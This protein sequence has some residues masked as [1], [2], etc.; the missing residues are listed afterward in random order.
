MPFSS[1]PF[2]IL[3]SSRA[4]AAACALVL[5]APF[6]AAQSTALPKSRLLLDIDQTVISHEGSKPNDFLTIG[7]WTYFAATGWEQIGREL[8]RTHSITGKTELVADINSGKASSFPGNFCNVGP[9]L[10]FAADGGRYGRE[11]WRSD[12][13]AKGTYLVKDVY[14]SYPSSVPMSL[15]AFGNRLVF[16]AFDG[17]TGWELWISDGT[18]AGTVLLKDIVR[19]RGSSLP[20]R[21]VVAGNTLFFTAT[22]PAFGT[23]LWKTDGTAKGTSLAR[24]VFAGPQSAI[25]TDSNLEPLGNKVLFIAKSSLLDFEP[26]VSDGTAKGTIRLKPVSRPLASMLIPSPFLSV[27]K[28]AYFVANSP[29]G[30]LWK[31]DGTV[32]GTV[33]VTVFSRN[34]ISSTQFARSGSR[35][36]LRIQLFAGQAN[37]VV[38]DGTAVGTQALASFTSTKPQPFVGTD[39]GVYLQSDGRLWYSSGTKAGTKRVVLPDPFRFGADMHDNRSGGVLFAG[40]SF[41]GFGSELWKVDKSQRVRL[42]ADINKLPGNAG[43]R[44]QRYFA[45]AGLAWFIAW[46]NKRQIPEIWRTDGTTRGTFSLDIVPSTREFDPAVLGRYVY[47]TGAKADKVEALWRSDGT[48]A[49]T[50]ALATFKNAAPNVAVAEGKIFFVGDGPALWVSDGT[51][52]GTKK[53][54]DIAPSPFRGGYY[55]PFTVMKGHV[56][57]EN[58]SGGAWE[59]WKSDGTKAGTKF[60]AATHADNVVV[61]GD[62]LYF[63]SR[64][65]EYKLWRS[66]GTTKGTKAIQT[67]NPRFERQ[68]EHLTAVGTKVFFVR[69]DSTGRYAAFVTGGGSDSVTRLVYLE[70]WRS[71]SG[72]GPDSPFGVVGPRV[73]VSAADRGLVWVTDG[74]RAGTRL[75]R[76]FA[77]VGFRVNRF[78]TLGELVT[79]AAFDAKSNKVMRWISDGTRQGTRQVSSFLPAGV[80]NESFGFPLSSV[81]TGGN[82]YFAAF[83]PDIRWEP[84]VLGPLAQSEVVVPGCAAGKVPS[85][86]A[87]APRLGGSVTVQVQDV[88]SNMAGVLCVSIGSRTPRHIGSGCQ[89][90]IDYSRLVA[91][92]VFRGQWSKKVQVPPDASLF[93]VRLNAQAAVGPTK[94]RPWGAD[95]SN[96]LLLTIGR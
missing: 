10:Y 36:F 41:T 55:R 54:T 14:A 59:F 22:T 2:A 56:F 37:L 12:G 42:V 81:F 79:F 83:L 73:L 87:N 66:D 90:V 7:L 46:N 86:V 16:S 44:P 4:L 20:D 38:T 47:F 76:D 45:G 15:T 8:Y 93:G 50:V 25:H 49:G 9:I 40:D 82:L 53:I 33:P 92:F 34:R 96:G 85:L 48:R 27:G 29:G 24:D 95:L 43:S 32:K 64:H 6:L 94:Q 21:L 89:H 28:T 23:E 61:A 88:P 11:L 30:T 63:L 35:I 1:L 80:S 72:F 69:R 3:V 51:A 65:P 77:G 60:M 67:W 18:R 58:R 5:T 78:A 68:P 84:F 62:N 74:T 70:S 26:Y 57:F 17:P 39:H 91:Q 75:F 71:N 31:T 19:G 52:K 13:T